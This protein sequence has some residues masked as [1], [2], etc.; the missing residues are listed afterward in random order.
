MMI[1]KRFLASLFM[2]YDEI[3]IYV[4][5]FK[6]STRCRPIIFNYCAEGRI[7]LSSLERDGI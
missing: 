4:R 6:K 7:F 3:F 1:K 5:K 2:Y